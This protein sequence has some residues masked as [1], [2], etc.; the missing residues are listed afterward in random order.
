MAAAQAAA[1]VATRGATVRG[2]SL[3]RAARRRG[4]VRVRS[5][6]RLKPMHGQAATP[7]RGRKGRA[8][9]PAAMRR[10]KAKTSTGEEA[11]GVKQVTRFSVLEVLW[12]LRGVWTFD[13]VQ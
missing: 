6:L 1:A 8:Q 13:L 5:V 4:K 10:R 3:A 12:A 2:A 9:P 11:E 7:R